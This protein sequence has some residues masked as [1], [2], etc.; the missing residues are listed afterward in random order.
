[1]N[2]AMIQNT[3]KLMMNSQFEAQRAVLT[4]NADRTDSSTSGTRVDFELCGRVLLHKRYVSS[5]ADGTV[6]DQLDIEKEA[7]ILSSRGR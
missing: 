6:W 2:Y 1:M 4:A 5:Q 7:I 3:K